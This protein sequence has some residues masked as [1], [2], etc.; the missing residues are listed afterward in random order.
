MTPKQY[1][2]KKLGHTDTPSG[3]NAAYRRGKA[4]AESGAGELAL[5]EALN[6]CM[7][8]DSRSQLSAGYSDALARRYKL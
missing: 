5:N 8:P 1:R 6:R 2:M 3:L 7:T 4:L